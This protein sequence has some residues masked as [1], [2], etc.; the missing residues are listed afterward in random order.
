MKP[1]R[2]EAQ[3][4][5][6]PSNCNFQLPSRASE[7]LGKIRCYSL[8]KDQI[9]SAVNDILPKTQACIESDWGAFEYKLKYFKKRLSRSFFTDDILSSNVQH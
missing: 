3:L 1:G 9:I 4:F 8:N 2:R 5:H 6:F 7:Y